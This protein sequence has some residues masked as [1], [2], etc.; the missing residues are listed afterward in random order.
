MSIVTVLIIIVYIDFDIDNHNSKISYTHFALTKTRP[1]ISLIM[2]ESND[3]LKID[4]QPKHICS[5]NGHE[6]SA[7]RANIKTYLVIYN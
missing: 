1:H 5:V 4:G 2:Y 7:I 3:L 6:L